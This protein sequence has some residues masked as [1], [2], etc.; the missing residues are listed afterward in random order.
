MDRQ[1][2]FASEGMWSGFVRTE[3]GAVSGWHHHGEH[4]SVIYVLSGAL[5]MEFGPGG[6]HTVD[7]GPGDFLHVPKGAVHR[8][9]NPSAEAA[10]IIVVRAGTGEST[11]NTDGPAPG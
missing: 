6:S 9:S 4:E 8:E 1:E 7:A 10:D 3:A 11:V 2:A 5:R